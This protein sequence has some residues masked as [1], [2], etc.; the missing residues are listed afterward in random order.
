MQQYLAYTLMVLGMIGVF[1][2]GKLLLIDLSILSGITMLM[3]IFSP[4]FHGRVSYI[5]VSIVI[6]FCIWVIYPTEKKK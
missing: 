1:L 3:A 5:I 6:L 2:K 4:D